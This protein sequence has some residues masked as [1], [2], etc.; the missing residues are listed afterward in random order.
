MTENYRPMG[1]GEFDRKVKI[2]LADQSAQ[3]ALGGR[4]TTYTV[5]AAPWANVSPTRGD[6]VWHAH[7]LQGKQG[8]LVKVRYTA[9]LSAVTNNGYHVE[10]R[11]RFFKV[12]ATRNPEERDER[13]ELLCEEVVGWQ[14]PGYVSA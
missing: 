5:I 3:T 12:L 2:W 7:H 6:E 8:Y 10:Y 1:A 14:P 9:A 4:L 13:I 11:S